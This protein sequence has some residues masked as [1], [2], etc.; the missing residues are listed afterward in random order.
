MTVS[1]ARR[2]LQRIAPGRPSAV[3]FGVFDGVHRGHRHLVAALLEEARRES[4]AAVAITFN[5]HPRTVLRPGATIAYLTSLEE[6]VELLQSLGLDAVGVL[7][8]TSEL[9]QLEPREFLG[10][11][12]D[13]LEMR[14]LLVGPD[15]AFGRN[16]AGTLEVSSKIGEEL[17]FRVEAAPMLDEGGEKVGST[18]VREALGRGDVRRVAQL[19]GR[20]FSLRGPVIEGDKR[21]R[22]LGFPTAN[23]AIGL[24]HALPAY[25]I[26]VSR[27]YV[28]ETAYEACTSIGVRP[29]F[30]GDEKPTVEA[31]IL[32]F[33]GDVYGEELRIELLERLRGE[34]RFESADELVAQMHKDIE[35]TRRYFRSHGD[36]ADG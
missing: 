17:G 11:L 13:E 33:D 35:Q 36:P 18:A 6:R 25:G 27:A 9:A 31:F 3:T 10:L 28:R 34:E 21:G 4:L 29:T 7:A 26:Y 15:F 22:E 20:P 30:E 8:F 14:V 2:E 12:A 24:D 5:P 16:R 1:L 19:L 32:D 23:I